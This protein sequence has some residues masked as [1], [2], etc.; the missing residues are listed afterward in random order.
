MMGPSPST[1]MQKKRALYSRPFYATSFKE[2]VMSFLSSWF[3][4]KEKSSNRRT[5]LEFDTLESRLVP[6]SVSGNAWIHPELVT[7][8]FIPDGTLVSSGVG[9]DAY[10]NLNANLGSKYVE[11]TWRAEILKA[12]QV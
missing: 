4:E 8:S 9:G 1:P 11:A 7:I 3:G 6:Y 10:N 12:A 5:Q 2:S